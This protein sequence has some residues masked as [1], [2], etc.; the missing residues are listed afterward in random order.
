MPPGFTLSRPSINVTDEDMQLPYAHQFNAGVEHQ[1]G[2]DWAA[3]VNVVHVRGEDMLR[4]DNINLGPPTVLTDENAP[5]LGVARPTPQQIGRPYYGSTNRLDP[6][7]NNIQ[8]INS[9][10]ISRYW[11][12]QFTVHKRMS[13]NY[14]LRASYTLSEAKDDASDFV[15]AEQPSNPYDKAA[16]YGYP[17][18]HQRHR[19]TL[20][21]V[22]QVP[23]TSDQAGNAAARVL[24]SDWVLA[25]AWRVR[26]GSPNNPAVGSDVNV[27]GNSGTDRP[28]V[29]G[30]ELARNSEI[31][32]D[33]RSIDLRLS[34][35]I[36]D[37]RAHLDPGDRRGVQPV[38]PGQLRR[39]EHDVG[40]GPRRAVD[41]RGVHVGEQPA[42]DPVGGEVRVL[43]G[44]RLAA[45]GDRRSAIGDR[46]TAGGG[47]RVWAGR[48][49]P[50]RTG[51]RLIVG[52]S[53]SGRGS[54][55]RR[56]GGPPARRRRVPRR[57][58]CRAEEAGGGAATGPATK[59]APR[60]LAVSLTRRYTEGSAS[61]CAKQ[62]GRPHRGPD[63]VQCQSTNRVRAGRQ[64]R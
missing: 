23:Y 36:R 37:G 16:E 52:G 54:G 4:S 20:T 59:G 55:W 58:A 24:L 60:A 50:V 38:Q 57:S 62:T 12:V 56:G 34:K 1:L 8:Q 18:E 41:L 3:A 31:G 47:G 9:G 13:H 21:G 35:R 49:G 22:W 61:R 17:A 25:T 39:G 28:I 11:G 27:D 43:I 33:Y 19:F 51:T 42:G 14:E 48:T 45:G 64:Q 46:L 6:N 5:S 63:P 10:S 29:D 53:P 2:Q 32:P 44:W 15:Q 40:H 26:S 30:N 7:F